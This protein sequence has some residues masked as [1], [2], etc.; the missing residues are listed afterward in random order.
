MNEGVGGHQEVISDYS[1]RN[2]GLDFW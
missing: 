2:A 1:E